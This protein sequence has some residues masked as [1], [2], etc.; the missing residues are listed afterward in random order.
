MYQPPSGLMPARP[1]R[2][3]SL[4]LVPESSARDAKG[5]RAA[6]MAL[7]A[8]TASLPRL[9]WAGSPLGP[10][11]TKSLCI[12]AARL[13]PWPCAMYFSS[14]AGECTSSTSAFPLAPRAIASPDPTATVLTRQWLPDSYSGTSVSSRPESWVL[15]VVPRI[16]VPPGALEG[17]ASL[18]GPRPGPPQAASSAAAASTAPRPPAPGVLPTPPRWSGQVGDA[19]PGDTTGRHARRADVRLAL[20]RLR[21]CARAPSG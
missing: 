21:R 15:V 5:A 13:T 10:S 4:A 16:S 2:V 14:A 8:S 9:A 19:T 6:A 20:R 1:H 7:S 3:S 18:W 11:S 17:D 12:T